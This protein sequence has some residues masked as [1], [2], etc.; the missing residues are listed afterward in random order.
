MGRLFELGV[1]TAVIGAIIVLCAWGLINYINL[2]PLPEYTVKLI[3]VFV[4]G[5]GV[6]IA[7]VGITCIII[8]TV[9]GEEIL[10]KGVKINAVEFTPEIIKAVTIVIIVVGVIVALIMGKLSQENFMYLISAILG[11]IGGAVA[12][13]AISKIFRR[14]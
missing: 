14:A 3:T 10:V 6:T 1:A 2:I 7:I 13:Y 4:F 8:S 9:I 5:A 12:S 11:A